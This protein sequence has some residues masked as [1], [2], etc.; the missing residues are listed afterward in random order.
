MPNRQPANLQSA[1]VRRVREEFMEM[2]GLRLTHA[3]A[4]RLWGLDSGTCAK[5][6]D[7][8]VSVNFLALNADGR[9]TRVYD[10]ADPAMPPPAKA[11]LQPQHRR[12]ARPA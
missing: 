1:L 4:Q 9:Y 6:L 11:D 7:V 10:G 12:H 3:Q 8:L 5:L 2:P